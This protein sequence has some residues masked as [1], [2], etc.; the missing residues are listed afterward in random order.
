MAMCD[1]YFVMLLCYIQVNRGC[2]SHMSMHDAVFRMALK[3]MPPFI[4]IRKMIFD[5]VAW[6]IVDVSS[7]RA[8][9]LV[10][11]T[12]PRVMRHEVELDFC[13]VYVTVDVHNQRLRPSSV[14]G[15]HYVQYSKAHTVSSIVFRRGRPSTKNAKTFTDYEIIRRAYP[16]FSFLSP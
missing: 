6:D 1:G 15:S 10:K 9:F 4:D 14:C 11:I 2:A 12:W 13:P 16:Y 5:L 8:D 3:K 7:Q